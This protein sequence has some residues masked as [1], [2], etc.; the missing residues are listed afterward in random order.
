MESFPTLEKKIHEAAHE[1]QESGADFVR[2]TNASQF[3]LVRENSPQG[4]AQLTHDSA[5]SKY[6]YQRHI[7]AGISYLV[8]PR[9]VE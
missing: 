8:C 1:L 4:E 9:L 2:M 5:D 6:V 7:V 3:F